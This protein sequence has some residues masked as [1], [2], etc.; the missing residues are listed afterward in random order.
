[1]QPWIMKLAQP[2]SCQIEKLLIIGLLWTK[3]M[4]T[5]YRMGDICLNGPQRRLVIMSCQSTMIV[6]VWKATHIQRIYRI[7]YLPLSL[8]QQPLILILNR[9]Y[10]ELLQ[11]CWTSGNCRRPYLM[12]DQLLLAEL[13]QD[14]TSCSSQS[15]ETLRH[16]QVQ[17]ILRGDFFRRG[18]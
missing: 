12:Q 3:I 15:C 1:M 4:S 11:V 2:P 16:H 6:P 13:S 14:M 18:R 5:R 7:W 10:C 8:K 17:D 9:Y